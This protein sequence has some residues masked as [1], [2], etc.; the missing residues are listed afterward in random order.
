MQLNDRCWYNKVCRDKKCSGCVR[1]AEMA[2]LMQAS[3]LPEAK[4][5]PIDLYAGTKNDVKMFTMLADLKD[6][7]VD[8]V[9]TGSNLYITSKHTGNG[10]TSWALKLLFRYFDQIWA[11]N[12][13]RTRGIFIHVPSFLLKLKDFKN[14]IS[15]ELRKN[16]E[17]CDLVIW[18]DIAS[19]ELSNYDY[20]QLLLFIDTRILSEKSNIFTGN[21]VE[22]DELRQILGE[23]LASR[24]FN[25]S[26]IV[27]FDGK[28][29]R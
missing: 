23:R 3:G 15:S 2:Y 8:F 10:K 16:I 5:R 18:D 4:W 20:S 14:P 26:Q 25:T 28:D 21:V 9:E 7:I 24:I 22:E 1:Y 27:T 17:N 13:F 19:T 6:N 11:G 29:Q 12:G